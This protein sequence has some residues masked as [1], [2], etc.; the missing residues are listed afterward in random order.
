MDERSRG[1]RGVDAGAGGGLG[2]TVAL[3]AGAALLGLAM[4]VGF[5][6]ATRP[7]G[8]F[9]KY[10]AAAT[11]SPAQSA[12]RALDYSPLYLALARTVVPR[13]GATAMLW[14]NCLLY[15]LTCAAVAVTAILLCGSR[16]G[17][18]A[19]VAAACYRPLLVYCAVLE[20]EIAIV[21]CLA[22]ASLAG[23]AARQSAHREAI[24]R[25]TVVVL[26]GA[27]GACLGLATL[28]RP[29][30]LL[31]VPVW[32]AW[33]AAGRRGVERRRIWMASVLAC[34][35]VVLPTVASRA[36][37]SGVP[38][39]MNP[40]P[41]FYEGNGPQA[42]GAAAVR[43]QLVDLLQDAQPE[44]SDYAHVAYRR[45]AAAELGRPASPWEAD[46]YWTTLALQ[47]MRRDP[48]AAALR[49]VGKAM[50]AAGPAEIHDLASATELDRRLRGVLPVAFGVLLV[51]LPLAVVLAPGVLLRVAGPA[52]IAG[53][54]FAVQIVFYAS[55]RQ[56]L[57]AA[58][59]LLV[60]IPAGLAEAA[61]HRPLP[62]RRAVLALAAGVAL[63]VAVTWFAAPLAIEHEA[64]FSELLG[65]PPS[66]F[67][68]ELAAAFDGR[69]W[70]PRDEEA[71]ERL[72]HARTLLGAEDPRAA[73]AVLRPLANGIVTRRG[74]L[75]SRAR[76][77]WAHLLVAEGDLPGARLVAGKAAR[78]DSGSLP[79][80][81]LVEA[82]RLDDASAFRGRSWWPAGVD[83][84]GAAFALGRELVAVR[85]V[86][87]ALHAASEPLRFFP[88]LRPALVAEKY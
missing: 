2:K 23:A 16:W 40:G 41:V 68:E 74:E 26:A 38:A 25:R 45:I 24:R 53:L 63:S 6:R 73:S 18:T 5:A 49:F 12:A 21:A 10:L 71:V 47:A 54:A 46:R 48:A 52:A 80:A 79:A 9:S 13:G 42:S 55:A 30:Y 7:P 14:I 31:L 44:Q 35:L 34:A 67:G 65:A 85:G 87:A 1:S 64:G 88:E 17:A 8:Y 4:S 15:A 69:A 37:E 50:L 83:P 28:L 20:P 59:G 75:L 70:R 56:R 11:A 58:L 57:P 22:L 81:A 61:R 76:Y 82:L 72:A 19:G 29:Q 78:D 27:A 3:A 51:L 84:L 43:P 86:P 77:L 36:R 32:A 33:I 60:L 66:T 39:I 62:G